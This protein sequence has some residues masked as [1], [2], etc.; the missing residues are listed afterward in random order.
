MIK[1]AAPSSQP[2]FLSLTFPAPHSGDPVD[3]DDPPSLRTP[4]P[5]P[6]HRD[7]FAAT[8]LPRPPSFNERRVR[9][10]PQIT[11]ERRRITPTDFDAIQ[12]NYQQEL[13]SLLS[14][15]DA[16]GNVLGAL[17][18]AGEL[19]NTLIVYTSDNGFFHGEHRIRSEKVLP[20]WPA[21]NVPLVMR[22]PGVLRGRTLKQLVANLDLAP[23]ILEAA[24]AV[25]GRVQ[26]G[27]SLFE[28]MRDPTLQVGREIVHENGAGVNSVPQ[29]RAIRN[30]RFLY[31]RH[32]TTGET[33]CTTC[34]R[35]PMSWPTSRTW[36]PTQ[37]SSA[38]SQGGCARS[39]GAPGRPAS[40]RRP[41]CG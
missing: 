37:A 1:R 39:S 9:D 28:L 26:D 7:A 10:K 34:A 29:Y 6:R 38:H 3:P 24:H 13:E 27:R 41:R 8:P 32:D 11:A 5:A 31:V 14:V 23:T 33:S 35:T 4:S 20:Y 15:D 36:T 30:D 19:E 21:A 22:G 17:A 2:F 40:P 25:P 16:V 18:D 12:E